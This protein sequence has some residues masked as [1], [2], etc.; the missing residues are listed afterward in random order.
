MVR[1]L[2][3]K[4]SG[5]DMGFDSDMG[6]LTRIMVGIASYLVSTKYNSK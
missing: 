4:V 1:V 6:T 2:V 3:A 5:S